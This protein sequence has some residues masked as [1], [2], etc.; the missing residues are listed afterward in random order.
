MRRTHR[1]ISLLILVG[2]IL[3]AVL[4]HTPDLTQSA[5]M[6]SQ[7]PARSDEEIVRAAWLLAGDVGVYRFRTQVVQTT[8]PAPTLYN[9]G[10]TSQEDHF[11][12]EGRVDRPQDVIEMS[13]GRSTA[14]RTAP[15]AQDAQYNIRIKNG[16]AYGRT[17]AGTWEEID[18]VGDIFA[19]GSDPLGFL[20]SARN[21]RLLGAETHTLPGPDNTQHKIRNTKYAFDLNGPALAAY[22]R[23][24]L[25]QQL[26]ERGELPDGINLDTSDA[27]RK[28]KGQGEIWL[29]GDGLPRRL[30]MVMAFPREDDGRRIKAEFT[31]NLYDFDRMALAKATAA[32]FEDT[33]AWAARA[34]NL[35][36]TALGWQKWW[37]QTGLLLGS[38]ALMIAVA[39]FMRTRAF[40]VAASGVVALSMLITPLLQSQQ[41]YAFSE[42]QSAR[43]AESDARQERTESEERA[44]E[45]ARSRYNWSPHQNPL[46]I[47]RAA[48]QQIEHTT[49]GIPGSIIT[50]RTAMATT[51]TDDELDTTDTD[52]DG[53]TDDEEEYWET[54]ASVD[55]TACDDPTDSDGDGLT[56]GAEVN[57]IGTYPTLADH[58]GDTITDSLEIAGFEYPVGSGEMWYLNPLET[59]TNGDS[60]TDGQE[61]P[62]LSEIGDGGAGAAY[63]SDT[64]GDGEPD[65]FDFDNDGDGV[66]DLTDLSPFS[67]I[68][69]ADD[70]FDYDTPF[71]LSVDNLEA[72]MP[73]FVEL[74]LRPVNAL[75]LTYS[76]SI[77][78]WPAGDEEGQIIRGND[79][80]FADTQNTAIRSSADNAANG[81]VLIYPVLEIYIPYEEDV[82]GNLPVRDTITDTVDIA[83]WLDTD[84]LDAY[85]ISV[86]QADDEGNLYVYVPISTVD[87]D[88][89][90]STAAFSAQMLYWPT[91]SPDG[92]QVSWGS[93]HEF[94]VLW[95]VQMIVDEGEGTDDSS[96]VVHIYSDEQWYI[97]GIDVREDHGFD[98]A[99]V[100]EDP[101]AADFT[102]DMLLYHDLLLLLADGLSQ[103]FIEGVDCAP[104]SLDDEYCIG[105]NTRLTVNEIYERF[106]QSSNSAIADNYRWYITDTFKVMMQSYDHYGYL[107]HVAMTDTVDFLEST[108]S[109]YTDDIPMLL[110]AQEQTYRT[111]NL[112]D[113]TPADSLSV[114]ISTVQEYV[115][116]YLNVGAYIYDADDAAWNNYSTE[117]FLDYWGTLLSE[118]DDFQPED[119]DDEESIQIAEGELTWMQLYY[120][121][122]SNGVAALVEIDAEP[123]LAED[124][125]YHENAQIVYR[126]GTVGS[127]AL[128]ALWHSDTVWKWGGTI[129]KGVWSGLKWL[130]LKIYNYFKSPSGVTIIY[131]NKVFGSGTSIVKKLGNFYKK[132][133]TLD[134]TF[135]LGDGAVAMLK[136]L[137]MGKLGKTCIGG[138]LVG[139]LVLTSFAIA[140]SVDSGDAWWE[141]AMTATIGAS[142]ALIA[143]QTINTMNKLLQAFHNPQAVLGVLGP[144]ASTNRWNALRTVGKASRFVSFAG[145]LLEV[146]FAWGFVAYQMLFSGS[147]SKYEINALIAYGIAYTIVAILLFALGFIP[148]IGPLLV[149]LIILVDL[150]AFLICEAT[151]S[152][153][154]KCKG[155]TGMLTEW[156]ASFIYAVNEIV[157]V[158]DANRLE[159]TIAGLDLTE[160][161]VGYTIANTVQ[162]SLKVTNTIKILGD[163]D[164]AKDTAFKYYLQ[165][166]E[167]NKHDNLDLGD[168]DW[169]VTSWFPD[170]G[171]GEIA[172]TLATYSTPEPLLVNFADAGVGI[173]RSLPIYLTEAYAIP[174][175]ECWFDVCSLDKHAGSLHLSIGDYILYDILPATLDDFF[176]L[177]S[178]DAGYSLDWG[179][180][181][182]LRFPRQKD[183]DNDGLWNSVDGGSDPD[184]GN[185]DTDDD[186]LSDYYEIA[187]GLDPESTPSAGSALRA[188]QK[189]SSGGDTD[190]DGLTD[191]E[192][193][194]YGSDPWA[195][196]GDGDGL[197]DVVEL[198]GWDLL[199]QDIDGNTF[200]V[201]VWSDP[202]LADADGDGLDDSDEYLYGLNPNMVED[203]DIINN[204][205]SFSSLD[206][207]ET[208]APVALLQFEE[209][210]GVAF[211]DAA[212]ANRA[213]LCT[214]SACPTA[215]VQGRYGYGLQFD[216]NDAL[217]I[218]ADD[219]F[220]LA[221]YS[222]G[223]W[224]KPTQT[225]TAQRYIRKGSSGYTNFN[226]WQLENSLNLKF[227]LYPATCNSGAVRHF[228]SNAALTENEW[229][230]VLVTYNGNTMALYING[231]LDNSATT[232]NAGV[233]TTSSDVVIG[234]NVTGS[235]DEVTVFDYVLDLA[236]VQTLYDGRYNL[237]DDLVLPGDALTYQATIQNNLSSR[238]AN[239]YISAAPDSED[240][241]IIVDTDY[242]PFSLDPEA[243]LVINGSAQFSSTATAGTYALD[244]VAG[245][246]INA[247]DESVLFVTAPDPDLGIYFE[248][249]Q[250]DSSSSS[251]IVGTLADG[252]LGECPETR[253]YGD[254]ETCPDRDD[255]G[256]NGYALTFDG[257]T[258]SFLVRQTEDDGPLSDLESGSFTLGAWIKPTHDAADTATRA[259]LGYDQTDA[260]WFRFNAAA[261]NN[262]FADEVGHYT[263]DC[264]TGECP[265]QGADLGGVPQA[266]I[267][268]DGV[269]D[270]L[271]LSSTAEN[272]LGAG[273]EAS[274]SLW[275][276]V[277]PNG[278][279]VQELYSHSNEGVVIVYL[280]NINSSTSMLTLYAK[281]YVMLDNQ[282]GWFSY[283]IETQIDSQIPHHIVI[284]EPSEQTN[285]PR[286]ENLKFYVDGVLIGTGWHWGW[287]DRVSVT[288]GES[289]W[290]IPDVDEQN[291]KGIVG[292]LALF[293]TILSVDQVTH[294]Y[295]HGFGGMPI[296]YTAGEQIGFA[297]KDDGAPGLLS[298]PAST[299]L[300]LDTWSHVTLVYDD[301]ANSATLYLNGIAVQ[302]ETGVDIEVSFDDKAKFRIGWAGGGYEH[303]QGSIDSVVLYNEALSDDVSGLFVSTLDENA[304]ILL[305]LDEIPGATQFQYG[306]DADEIATCTSFCPDTGLPGIANWAVYFD[307]NARIDIADSDAV[308]EQISAFTIAA[309]VKTTSDS[310]SIFQSIYNN[311]D[312][313]WLTPNE[314]YVAGQT[315]AYSG[316]T[317][318]EWAHVVAIY[319]FSGS[320]MRVYVNGSKQAVQNI[321]ANTIDLGIARYNIGHNFDGYLDDVRFYPNALS[322]S[323]S[324]NLYKFTQPTLRAQ[325]DE[326]S[327]ATDLDLLVYRDFIYGKVS[328]ENVQ[329]GMPGRLGNAAHFYDPDDDQ[330]TQIEI[331]ADA[332]AAEIDPFTI[333]FWL[334]PDTWSTNYQTEHILNWGGLDITQQRDVYG[335]T[336]LHVNGDA[337]AALPLQAGEW[338]QVAI[339]GDSNHNIRFYLDGVLQATE[340]LQVFNSNTVYQYIGDEKNGT[341]GGLVDTALDELA[342]L[343]RALSSAEVADIYN[344]ESR[345]YRA[346]ATFRFTVDIDAPTI[347]LRTDDD[348][349]PYQS[350]VLDVAT[351]DATGATTLLDIG[352]QAPGA[353]DYI[354]ENAPACLDAESGAAWCPTFDPT[355]FGGEGQY[356]LQFRAVDTVG[357]ESTSQVYNTF[358]DNTPPTVTVA[359]DGAWVPATPAQD[360]ELYWTLTLTGAI[361]DPDLGDGSAAGSGVLTSNVKINLLDE[362]GLLATGLGPQTASVAGDVWS[363]DYVFD[364]N[365]PTG[366]YTIRVIAEDKV[367]NILSS[368]VGIVGSDI[369]TDASAPDVD[370]HS[371]EL[372][373]DAITS[374]HT[375]SGTGIDLSPRSG[376]VLKLNFDENDGGTT[377]YDTSD[378]GTPA[379]CVACP[380]LTAGQFG[381]ALNFSNDYL[382][383][384]NAQVP[385]GDSEYTLMAWI[386]PN[387]MAAQSIIGWGNW[388]VDDEY[389]VLRLTATG[390]Q[391]DWGNNA[392]TA[393]TS[394][395]SGAWHH[396]AATFD[397]TTRSIYL[398][399]IKIDSDAPSG[400]NVT[401]PDDLRIGARANP[402]GEYFDGLIDQVQV[403]YRALNRVELYAL[404]QSPVAGVDAVDVNFESRAPGPL[405]YNNVLPDGAVLYLPFNEQSNGDT[406]VTEFD[407]Y[408]GDEYGVV[409]YIVCDEATCPTTGASG[410]RDS[411]L[412]FD[413]EDQGVIIS[414]TTESDNGDMYQMTVGAWFRA[415]DLSQGYRQYIYSHKT[416]GRLDIYFDDTQQLTLHAVQNDGLNTT[417]TTTAVEQGRWHYVTAVLSA[418]DQLTPDGLKLY[419]DGQ[420]VGSSEGKRLK[421]YVGSDTRHLPRIG[422][423]AK[424]DHTGRYGIWYYQT[425]WGFIGQ[426][427]EMSLFNRALDAQ[428]IRAL[429]FQSDPQLALD[430]DDGVASD[431]D[432]LA[433][434]PTELALAAQLVSDDTTNKI[435]TGHV[436]DGALTLDGGG[437]HVAISASPYLDTSTNTAAGNRAAFSQMLWVYPSPADNSVYPILSSGAYTDDAYAY[438]FLAVTDTTKL[439][440][441]FGDGSAL[442]AYT[443]GDILTTD[444]WNHV[445][446]TF[447][448]DTYRVY[449]NGVEVESTANFADLSPA[450]TQQFDLGR[451]G[452]G[453][454]FQG[455]LDALKL[456]PRVLDV[457]EI[458]ESYA[459]ATW[460]PVTLTQSGAALSTW[461][462]TPPELE[463]AYLINARATDAFSNTSAS[464]PLWNGTLDTIAPRINFGGRQLGAGSSAQTV[465]TFT[466][467]DINLDDAT[468]TSPCSEN[469]VQWTP[470][471]SLWFRILLGQTSLSGGQLF[472]GSAVCIANG[473]P[474]STVDL[475]ACDTQGNCATE[476]ITPFAAPATTLDAAI[477]APTDYALLGS[478]DPISVTGAA[479]ALN[480]LETLTV[481]LND[482]L[483]YTHTWP[484]GITG[485]TWATTWTP[486]VDGVHTL[487]AVVRD[488]TGVVLTETR[489]VN[490]IVSVNPPTITLETAVLTRTH[491]NAGNGKL[492]LVGTTSSTVGIRKVTV[493]I[494]SGT[495]TTKVDA[496]LDGESWNAN[497]YLSDGD[498]PDG[499]TYTVTITAKDYGGRTS[500]HSQAVI[501]DVQPPAQVVPGLGADG[502]TIA[503]GD[504]IRAISS[505]LTLTWTAGSDGSGLSSYETGWT[506][507]GAYSSTI[508][509]TSTLYA[510]TD[511]RQ[512]TYTATDGTRLTPYLAATDVYGNRGWLSFGNIYVDSALTPDYIQLP[513]SAEDAAY[514]GWMDSGCTLLNVDRRMLNVTAEHENLHAEQTFHT[515]WDLNALRLVW[516]GADWNTSGDLFV[517]LD[518]A[519][520]GATTL[521]DPYSDTLTHTTFYLPGNLPATAINFPLNPR[522]DYR[523][524]Q[525]AAQTAFGAE[526][527]VWVQD[528]STASLIAWN[529]STW[530]TVNVLGTA[531]FRFS[532]SLNDG[533]TDILIPFAD[534]G[535]TDPA[536]NSLGLLAFA[537]ADPSTSSGQALTLWAT[538]PSGNPI[539][540]SRLIDNDTL[541]AQSEIFALTLAY[542]WAGLGSGLCPS[543][544]GGDADLAFSLSVEP[545]GTVYSFQDDDL[546]WLWDSLHATAYAPDGRDNQ[547]AHLSDLKLGAIGTTYAPLIDGQTVT[548]TLGYHNQGTLTATNVSADLSGV[549]ALSLPGGTRLTGERRDSQT[550]ALGDI[551]PGASGSV[552]FNALID[553]AAAQGDYYADCVINYPDAPRACAPYLEV[554]AVDV[555]VSIAGRDPIDWLWAEHQV[556]NTAP[557]FFDFS[558]PNYEIALDEVT[559]SGYAH[560]D[561]GIDSLD[562]EFYISGYT[563]QIACPDSA[564][565]DGVWAC[566]VDITGLTGAGDLN[567]GNLFTA[568]VRATDKLGQTGEWSPSHNL[569]VDTTL[570]TTTVVVDGQSISSG[571]TLNST[572]DYV[573]SGQAYDE[574]ALD[575]AEI[576][577]DGACYIAPAQTGAQTFVYQDSPAA[578]IAL[579]GSTTCDGNEIVRTFTVGES[580]NVSELNVGLNI[581]HTFRDDVRAVLVSPPG[582]EQT[583]VLG[584]QHQAEDSQHLD[585][586]LADAHGQAYRTSGDHNAATPYYNN[587]RR[588][589]A[590]L[591]TFRGQSAY[592]TWTLRLCDTAPNADDGL[593]HHA[594]LT[595]IPLARGPLS[596]GWSQIIPTQAG[597]D[598]FSQVVTVTVVDGAG[599][600]SIDP[601]Q[602]SITVDNAGPVI[603]MTQVVTYI[604]FAGL[605]GPVTVL[606]GDIA[607]GTG[608]ARLDVLLKNPYNV[609]RTETLDVSNGQWDYA[610]QPTEYGTY[611][612]WLTAVDSV[613]NVTYLGPYPVEANGPRLYKS[614]TP[615]IDVPLGGVMTYTLTFENPD[616]ITVTAAV[617]TDVLPVQLGNPVIVDG[618]ATVVGGDSIAWTL[619][620]VPAGTSMSTTYTVAV[621]SNHYYYDTAIVNT[622]SFGAA[623]VTGEL[624]GTASNFSRIEEEAQLFIEDGSVKPSSTALGKIEWGDY[625]ND[626]DLDFLLYGPS[627]SDQTWIYENAVVTSTFIRRDDLSSALTQVGYGSAAWGDYDNDGDLDLLLT[628]CPMSFSECSGDPISKVYENTGDDF[629]KDTRANLPGIWNGA[630]AWG[631]Y[632]NDGDLDI[633]LVGN[634]IAGIYENTGNG[635]REDT[636]V[637]LPGLRASGA[638]W[639]DYD[640]D[641]DLDILLAGVAGS[642]RITY[643]YKN[644]DHEFRRDNS[645][646]LPGVSPAIV[647]WGDFD[648]DGLLDILL[649]GCMQ[650]KCGSTAQAR[651]Y[652]NT[653]ARFNYF[654][655][656]S[657]IKN[658]SAAWGDYDNDGD[659]D[660]LIVGE[661]QDISNPV[662]KVYRYH[663]GSFI[664]SSAANLPPSVSGHASWADYDNDGDL[665][666]LQIGCVPGQAC[667]SG[668]PSIFDFYRQ[669]RNNP[670]T[671]PTAP[672]ILSTAVDGALVTLNWNGGNDAETPAIGLNYNL[673]ITNSADSA[674]TLAPMAFT[675]GISE[676]LRLLPTL[677]NAQHALTTTIFITRPAVYTWSVQSIDSAFVGSPWVAAG[678]FTITALP[679][680]SI[681]KAFTPAFPGRGDPVT[682]T[683]SIANTGAL[684]ATTVWVYDAVTE[685]LMS[686]SFQA[687]GITAVHTGTISYTW[688]VGDLAPGQTGTITITGQLSD[689]L[690]AGT[691]VK[692]IAT[693]SAISDS[694]AIDNSA[695]VA[696][697]ISG[698]KV[699]SNA[700]LSNVSSG[701]AI[702]GD[703][704]GD[705]DLDVFITGNNGYPADI[706]ENTG[707]GFEKDTAASINLQGV[708]SGDAAWGD[709][710]N[711]GDLDLFVLGRYHDGSWN[712]LS[713]LYENLQGVF[714]EDTTAT[715]VF[716]GLY[717]GSVDWGDY[718]ND[719][720]LDVLLTGQKHSGQQHAGVYEN[721]SGGFQLAASLDG[722]SQSDA[723]WGDYDND[724]ALDILMT[725][726]PGSSTI[727]RVYRNTGSTFVDV[728]PSYLT[729]V[730]E[731]KVLWFDYDS[732]GDLDIYING[733][734]TSPTRKDVQIYENVGGTFIT[735]TLA[736]ENLRGVT[737]G[738]VD[739]GDYD[740]DGDPDLVVSGKA[741]SGNIGIIYANVGGIFITDT[742]ASA[743][744]PSVYQKSVEWGDY[745]GD[746]DLD[747]VYSKASGIYRNNGLTF[748]TPPDAP[749]NLI[750]DVNG[751]TVT[752][753]WDAAADNESPADALSYNVYVID[754]ATGNQMLA[755]M[756]LI[757]GDNDGERLIPA[758]GNAQLGLTATVILPSGDY[759]WSVQAVDPAFA[760]SEWAT[761]GTL[762]IEGTDMGISQTVSTPSTSSGQAPDAQ[763]G[764]TVTYTLV[765]TNNGPHIA[766]NVIISDILPSAITPLSFTT[767]GVPVSQTNVGV[768]TY[769]W[770]VPDIAPGESG[771][772]TVTGQVNTLLTDTISTTAQLVSPFYDPEPGNDQS[773]TWLQPTDFCASYERPVL[774]DAPVAFWRL[775][776]DDAVARNAGS[777]GSALDGVY[778]GG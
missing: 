679:N 553:V 524:D 537:S 69:G 63:C 97:T 377:F 368:T 191:L 292:D 110:F 205:L 741:D 690:P 340:V 538:A 371:W 587:E 90:A 454:Y 760:G 166:T 425:V 109:A 385:T 288:I 734:K 32:P 197:S 247:P 80:T 409:D 703:Y 376:A 530:E 231:A 404:A 619:T 571:A 749:T 684:T 39:P 583:F 300:T 519:A 358:V 185:W 399:G 717:R 222:V 663:Q 182:D 654:A 389:N 125:M 105:D 610:F 764:D 145:L 438:P 178:K 301:A 70:F 303:F 415:E 267:T 570:P 640:N 574:R 361:T 294:L 512:D 522:T 555:A 584:T 608:V 115:M 143:V 649:V 309:W 731:G 633:L 134:G 318:G 188:V 173:N 589:S 95:M 316:N 702:W 626:G 41:V 5:A 443:T 471:S 776:D 154:E 509:G 221:E 71:Y 712:T 560:D 349:R 623:T 740:S 407:D 552:S 57:T 424:L 367:G 356:N 430:F 700:N 558:Q 532:A 87:D 401:T 536:A 43:R 496:S 456:Y 501:V 257:D 225:S 120:M 431:G 132:I 602:F 645:V 590:P 104:E 54:C 58:D 437:D 158:S 51:D 470:Y 485:T 179:Q 635:F 551:A 609:A 295:E 699:D 214:G 621:T 390:V 744:L 266:G 421:S 20:S 462:S 337:S 128:Q 518:T 286:Y 157:D 210:E 381:Q 446:A 666:I 314:F 398:D 111:L 149:L 597:S 317:N 554:A 533:Q 577:V 274:V 312:M 187:N 477:L 439:H 355:Q 162:A 660:V 601:T 59:D 327:D 122:L 36:A 441:G 52:G 725:G 766:A 778:A 670:N 511:P 330:T 251:S 279:D 714:V 544:A 153:D 447:D 118:L 258:D 493:D 217:T 395:L 374:T 639:G 419:L 126:Q 290:D 569:L 249:D 408:S 263:V 630:A 93:A 269:D 48:N 135:D 773:T 668:D 33:S 167:K 435:T 133:A 220:D 453:H 189:T 160:A 695:D 323:Q 774:F 379:T 550:L 29:D 742:V 468:L 92:A 73:T 661:K 658:G 28:V 298:G 183:A 628:G 227:D 363:V 7:A 724:G 281:D 715:T 77:F 194:R 343:S 445:A 696:F 334:K 572:G 84:T 259:I 659:L 3:V 656:L 683:L 243:A 573:V 137:P 68:G 564:P 708:Q 320:Q 53:L 420:L 591:N 466:V 701:T 262:S 342:F 481:T 99:I 325:F 106:N 18:N 123:W 345:W 765:F 487:E 353:G 561:A 644:V 757:G 147:L 201:R 273:D 78:D 308:N 567:D 637:D 777:T 285:P 21:I 291:F 475:T 360:T 488:R 434:A 460:Q 482:G 142:A 413:G 242:Y 664:N 195:A 627:F 85:G 618:T 46:E 727:A 581:T 758:M 642:K 671:R 483:F 755:S 606:G 373:P 181:G 275:F 747:L 622:A 521:Y 682:Y 150:L 416:Y 726:T 159:Y 304:D 514:T 272:L 341:A 241:P 100:G 580:F 127:L 284:T 276:Q 677:G 484:A 229:N 647:E 380:V 625:D 144:I 230:H 244:L 44:R 669:D 562:L 383:I 196:D 607:D 534:L 56:D 177:T 19:P 507:Y 4:W 463:G 646:T 756:S 541:A 650:S 277:D 624:T 156:L 372:G 208:A 545:A 768:L 232:S 199:Y 352:I 739:W 62:E 520:G 586:L 350:A 563:S 588:P 190:G 299:D 114:D 750:T 302:E 117:D 576:C 449:V 280:D 35:P 24:Q 770:N 540:D 130:P 81:D 767:A 730:Y 504:T 386:K 508:T 422:V 213:A 198:E 675:Q 260:I 596:S 27:Y 396:V 665:D 362:E 549:F 366:Q 2:V 585:V 648:N 657:G 502:Q 582:T 9:A 686:P 706:Y 26:R 237:N 423:G 405:S 224:V 418:T 393:A 324:Q 754:T 593:Y 344:R 402:L 499:R 631:D 476:I 252:V 119:P 721:I 161:E 174:I 339:V 313:F 535:I 651:V 763:L 693:I 131:N 497:W 391:N 412:T 598:N 636:D 255:I 47:N 155:I 82:Y 74:Q 76:G 236:Q 25:E 503:A 265:I 212:K 614:G 489:P 729:G 461:S 472:E 359:Y 455:Q 226:V 253:L 307:G 310:G 713:I 674:Y 732:D 689:S 720:D 641:G 506:V 523:R 515:T 546:F 388:G 335:D 752:L 60:L 428:E 42:R 705:G 370:L 151:D 737:Y 745:D 467:Q 632:D 604:S 163:Q 329:L 79:T 775:S 38:L 256:I 49:T 165:G 245:G 711:D 517:Y 23:D 40:R 691:L 83:G 709:Y 239:G 180:E 37:T 410:I 6:P 491:Y 527:L 615:D 406:L 34:L 557:I 426:I 723:V 469:A 452:A 762:V 500:E 440:L 64:D 293:P 8:Y 382:G 333:M 331:I 733:V 629:V 510:P 620:N 311:P 427:D 306:Y 228:T 319:N 667:S 662:S 75:Q 411:A 152:D 15:G 771:I 433:T 296:L 772:I 171:W 492:D 175:E 172:R 458:R 759:V 575:Y 716:P 108:Y 722:V 164:D 61:C 594:R 261:E 638:A 643:I 568:R 464:L 218:T 529:G 30:T 498:T 200:S 124:A 168:T 271:D 102:D 354:W 403:Y 72:D 351:R 283:E 365:R 103:T 579:D 338:Q 11:A 616:P 384:A 14:G 96:S 207:S 45:S 490:V 88:L 282:G 348:Y 250:I 400:L 547:I 1:S 233:C 473:H 12:F 728:T 169:Q 556:D 378:S 652:R 270:R 707:Y 235:L 653:G 101:T 698:F 753:G 599:N 129:G 121:A 687:T 397:G 459:G 98:I 672:D 743:G 254:E 240:D 107:S 22:V 494:V 612:I 50:A 322:E 55:D 289:D 94:R 176:A 751:I 10:K 186:G 673:M 394:D 710:D 735:D 761:E 495:Q 16:L 478:I 566:D 65:V 474:A 141:V 697:S 387:S 13:L 238:Y 336:W 457:L 268:F 603:T 526:Y 592:G 680:V 209:T 600:R 516:S 617:I 736:A 525:A 116:A 193:L 450:P 685:T 278:P 543:D 417:I 678:T 264:D 139:V 738:A 578:P 542:R 17:S 136:S 565:D 216:G 681:N 392:L 694:Y 326:D 248:S 432:G 605:T 634:N 219:A 66:P 442:H 548:Y 138:A 688:Q 206:V 31:T 192:E 486:T 448:G 113:L 223:L 332:I 184:D 595:L 719:G 89:G 211:G 140:S 692:N 559:F 531:Q 215:G 347:T 321:S 203:A 86:Q 718:D 414:A 613:G 479:Y 746:G 369:R 357:N 769:T 170:L 204:A 539:N 480:E 146:A 91:P 429:M 676:G 328:I 444:A 375:L 315:L 451:D 246:V 704:D 287:D 655:T 364:G 465:Y 148:V 112:D 436:G 611:Q 202:A 234:N 67:F 505:T 297:Y 748:N 305:K 513:A 528:D 346:V